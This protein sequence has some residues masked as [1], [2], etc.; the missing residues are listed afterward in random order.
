MKYILALP[1]IVIYLL[2]IVVE[3]IKYLEHRIKNIRQ[4]FVNIFIRTN[5]NGSVYN[6]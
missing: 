3:L 1:T 5:N 6:K 2:I 4:T